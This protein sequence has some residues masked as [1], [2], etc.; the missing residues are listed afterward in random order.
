MTICHFNPTVRHACS[1]TS[2]QDRPCVRG[3]GEE[4]LKMALAALRMQ[5][6]A[7]P[8]FSQLALVLAQLFLILK[9]E[10]IAMREAGISG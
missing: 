7:L 9:R 8:L 5:I 6:D 10:L 4:N 2:N 3:M 1:G